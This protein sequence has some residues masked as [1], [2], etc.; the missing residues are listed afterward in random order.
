M[1]A[2]PTT[3]DLFSLDDAEDVASPCVTLSFPHETPASIR[4]IPAENRVE[5]S[6]I[7]YD[8]F[9]IPDK[10][11]VRVSH[12]H[13]LISGCISRSNNR[14]LSWIFNKKLSLQVVGRTIHLYYMLQDNDFDVV[15]DSRDICNMLASMHKN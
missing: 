10:Y 14:T 6:D 4:W 11:F 7:L 2:S 13:K 5:I 15:V 3:I 8:D 12:L 9:S 1:I